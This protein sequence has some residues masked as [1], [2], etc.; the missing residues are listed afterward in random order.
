MILYADG[1]PYQ[2]WLHIL[3]PSIYRL[4][5]F[6]VAALQIMVL[7]SAFNGL[8]SPTLVIV[9]AALYTCLKVLQ[10]LSWHNE[11]W[12]SIGILAFDVVVCASLVVPTGGLHSP[13]L[14]FSI[15][16][17]L[18][19]ALFLDANST[20]VAAII[21]AAYVLV[22]YL[23]DP[24]SIVKPSLDAVTSF[25]VYLMALMLSA[26]LPFWINLQLKQ[27]LESRAMIE[28]RKRLS[29]EV[30]DGT[31]QALYGLR[32]QIQ[33]LASRLAKDDKYTQDVRELE[34]MAAKME[35]SARA[36]L[37]LLRGIDSNDEFVPQLKNQLQQL[38]DDLGVNYRLDVEDDKLNIER[39]VEL[40]LLF[41]SQE[42]LRNI[43]KHSEAHNITVG[44]R[45]ADGYLRMEITDD[46][47]GF[48]M[49]QPLGKGSG[50]AIM[51]ERAES[52]GGKLRVLSV[53]GRGTQVKVEVQRT[54]PPSLIHRIKS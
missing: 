34:V 4:V 49:T 38:K 22:S 19:S 1:M 17:V 30:H 42:A 36:S 33:M 7:P 24:F 27:R 39:I 28:E 31:C 16:P 2:R 35:D 44:I 53:P 12:A 50:I 26:I 29:R 52:I 51:K 45:Q 54:W 48:D 37:E 47:C 18:Y 40:E 10:P 3:L 13:F 6:A 43:R 9:F 20:T 25:P 14:L 8:V 23:L 5:A 41:I 32:W 11:R 21:T 15:S 46:G